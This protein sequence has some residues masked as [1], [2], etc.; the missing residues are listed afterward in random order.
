MK[1]MINEL[2]AKL[3]GYFWLPCPVCKNNFGGHEW[4][5]EDCGHVP[6]VPAIRDDL[7]TTIRPFTGI[8]PTCT[9][10][11]AGCLAVGYCPSGEHIL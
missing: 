7:P 8:C 1:R 4:L 6:H 11:G 10:N 2:Y 3:N 9:Y 5:T